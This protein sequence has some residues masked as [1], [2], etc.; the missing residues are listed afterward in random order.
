MHERLKVEIEVT[1]SIEPTNRPHD[2]AR[3]SNINIIFILYRKEQSR[4]VQ[5]YLNI[6]LLM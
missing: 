4:M 1:K 3:T 5:T 6:Y 2:N